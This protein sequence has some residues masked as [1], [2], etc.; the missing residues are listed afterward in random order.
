MNKTAGLG[1]GILIIFIAVLLITA[2]AAS[3][4]LMSA[5]SFSIR[6]I[7]TA[8]ETKSAVSTMVNFLEVTATNGRS[9]NVTNFT[10]RIK[11]TPGSAPIEIARTLLVFDHFNSHATLSY[12][13]ESSVCEKNASIGFSTYAIEEIGQVFI[14]DDNYFS[15]VWFIGNAVETAIGIDLDS[16][17][18]D[19]TVRTC[20][21]AAGTPCPEPY[22]GTHLRFTLSSAGTLYAPLTNDN[23]SLVFLR[24]GA[25]SGMDIT[26]APV[27]N[28]GYMTGSR[29]AGTIDNQLF[30]ADP[31]TFAIYKNWHV[32]DDDL[33]MDGRTDLF[34]VNLSHALVHLS[35]NA[36]PVAIELN[37]D[38]TGGNNLDVSADI[39]TGGTTYGRLRIVGQTSAANQIDE[40]VT[41]SITPTN[42]GNG[43]Y[44]LVYD[45][46]APNSKPGILSRGD[47]ATL[48]FESPI[49]IGKNEEVTLHVVPHKG[50]AS[51]CRFE[52]P[53][54]ITT[55]QL[56]LYP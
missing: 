36:T 16:D 47:V 28:Y 34:A 10:A 52:T 48:C 45:I 2:V 33:D 23:G 22:N 12:R 8:D 1:I 44:T 42:Q 46:R 20:G 40:N 50:M 13:G 21:F 31:L 43:H 38:L 49:P 15:G 30:S 54:V 25:G 24:T 9:G 11:V 41:I 17:G 32:L 14:Y 6:G 4:I 3:V 29:T 26:S 53:N 35:S 18:T 27:G 5:G 7:Q 39:M 51:V 19:D 55:Y 37:E 56:H